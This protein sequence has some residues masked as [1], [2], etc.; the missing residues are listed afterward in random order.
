MKYLQITLFFILPFAVTGQNNFLDFDGTNDVV[1][2]GDID[3]L[4]GA[5]QITLETWVRI[6]NFVPYTRIFA[7]GLPTIHPQ[8]NDLGLSLAANPGEINTIMRNGSN[9][10][11]L[12]ENVITI[13][14]WHHLAMVF[15][16]TLNG[17]ANRLK[18]YVD[19]D[20][21]VQSTYNNTVPATT[22]DNNVDLRLFA[23]DN[24]GTQASDGQMDEVR[25]WNVARSQTEIQTFMNNELFGNEPGLVAYYNFNEGTCGAN[26]SAPAV[27]ALTDLAGGDNNGTLANFDL[28]ASSLCLS[29]W[30]CNDNCPS[31]PDNGV[32][33]A[34]S[35]IPT[36]GE[37]GLITLGLLLLSFGTVT[38][39]RNKRVLVV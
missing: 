11:G 26:N 5:S 36:M 21:K 27:N 16:G 23:F 33:P 17:D 34:V 1:V 29:N 35:A 30:V 24:I 22:P 19:G 15:D 9:T 13:G 31:F 32:G 20:L 6:D 18:L 10:V 28:G 8:Y 25:I 38:I 7:K 2:I 39:F 14:Q 12:A 37:W 3:E 4:D